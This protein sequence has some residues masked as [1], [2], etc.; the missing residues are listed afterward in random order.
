[1]SVISSTSGMLAHLHLVYIPSGIY[2][3]IY[4]LICTALHMYL[5]CYLVK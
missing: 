5:V 3:F 4:L 2:L 1:M